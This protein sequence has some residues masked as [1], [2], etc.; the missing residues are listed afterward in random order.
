ME[1]RVQSRACSGFAESRQRKSKE[2]FTQ[3]KIFFSFYISPYEERKNLFGERKNPLPFLRLPAW[4]SEGLRKKRRLPEKAFKIKKG[5]K[6]CRGK[7][8]NLSLPYI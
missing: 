8:I 7:K 3:G 2:I 5:E 4:L 1:Q 6:I